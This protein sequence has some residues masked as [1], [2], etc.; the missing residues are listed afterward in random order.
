MEVFADDTDISVLLLHHWHVGLYDITVTSRRSN[1][2]WSIKEC[3][4]ALPAHIQQIVL[5]LHAFTG[6]DTTSAIFGVGKPSAFRLFR[7]LGP[8]II[9]LYTMSE[10]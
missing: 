8:I 5:F 2:S 7:G 6:C 10:L 3:K 1:K 4:E 9:Y